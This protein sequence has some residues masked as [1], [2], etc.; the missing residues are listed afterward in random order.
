MYCVT[1][2]KMSTFVNSRD[3]Q[4]QCAYKK[5]NSF[6]IVFM[7]KSESVYVNPGRET[8]LEYWSRNKNHQANILQR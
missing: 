3:S 6:Y 4:S 8:G 7:G 1:F 5:H 2:Y